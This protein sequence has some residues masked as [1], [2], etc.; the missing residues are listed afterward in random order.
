[1]FMQTEEEKK[2]KKTGEDIKSAPGRLRRFLNPENRG[3]P[4]KYVEGEKE[5]QKEN[6]E[7]EKAVEPT[8]SFLER[9]L[10]KKR[11]K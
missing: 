4:K 7:K 10:G 9:L 3:K 5:R 6:E 2:K 8:P 11:A 1:M